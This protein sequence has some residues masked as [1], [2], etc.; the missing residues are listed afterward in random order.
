MFLL[1]IRCFSRNPTCTGTSVVAVAYGDGVAIMTDRLVSYGKMARYKHVTRQYRV[2]NDVVVAFG[3]DH[4]DF[5]WLQN[6]I[7]R[8]VSRHQYLNRF[9]DDCVFSTRFL[10]FYLLF[11]IFIAKLNVF[12]VETQRLWF[13]FFLLSKTFF[14]T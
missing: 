13:F 3:G 12:V 4:A 2:N 11:L 14:L 1:N 7:E 10:L 8:Q 6:V 9:L 5:Q